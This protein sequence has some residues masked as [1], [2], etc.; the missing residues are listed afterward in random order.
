MSA[1]SRAA[2]DLSASQGAAVLGLLER[3]NVPP[4]PMFYA[5]L[6]D[7]VAGVKD[8]QTSRV[9]DILA[10]T[11]TPVGERLYSE[12][13]EP[14]ESKETTER[15]IAQIV[16]RLTTLDLLIGESVQASE[17]HSVALRRAST[18]LEAAHLDADLLR[19]WVIS[20]DVHNQRMRRANLA[21]SN[22]LEI[23]RA[24][25]D[26]TRAEIDRS[27]DVSLRDPLTGVANRGGLDT[28][29]RKL[30][31]APAGAGLSCAVIDIDHFKSLNDT[32]GHPVGDQVL[33]I[34]TRALLAS[35]RANDIVGRTGGDE[36]VVLLPDTRLQAAHNVADGIR[37]M[38]ADSDLTTALGPDILGGITVSIGVAQFEPGDTV[39]S[40]VDR[41][42]R[43]LY[44]AKHSGRNRVDS[45]EAKS[46]A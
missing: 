23:A 43:G 45:L 7:Y 14:Y 21:L 22:E 13:V 34:V 25:L 40:F 4:L 6:F 28:I 46:A 33:M 2:I 41:A 9:S 20:L 11:S 29:L 26:D 10:D 36:F 3:A 19:D 8:L 31:A 15:A 5:L 39:A 32:Y 27:R 17:E 30:T 37:A 44:R 42:D 38:I 1:L 18:D 16:A 35:A 24:E 12:F